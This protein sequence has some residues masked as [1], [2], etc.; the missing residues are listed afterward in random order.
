MVMNPMGIGIVNNR[1]CQRGPNVRRTSC[2]SS[3][4]SLRLWSQQK[5]KWP[6]TS[7][8]LLVIQLQHLTGLYWTGL[9]GPQPV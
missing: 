5:I 8:I 3:N 2:Q 9:W 6:I 1:H 7:I 4:Q